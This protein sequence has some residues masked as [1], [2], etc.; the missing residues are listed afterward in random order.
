VC[1]V[2]VRGFAVF[3]SLAFWQHVDLVAE[4][5]CIVPRALLAGYGDFPVYLVGPE[6]AIVKI[7]ASELASLGFGD[8]SVPEPISGTSASKVPGGLA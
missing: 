4:C 3:A 8:S 2:S 1:F 6:R 7:P 5:G